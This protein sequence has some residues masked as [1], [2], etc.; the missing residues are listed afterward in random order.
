MGFDCTTVKMVNINC[1]QNDHIVLLDISKA[2]NATPA[3]CVAVRSQDLDWK[4][5]GVPT[6]T[7][8]TVHICT[9][10]SKIIVGERAIVFTIVKPPFPKHM[11]C[12]KNAH[13]CEE[14]NKK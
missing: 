7:T 5:A 14:K 8:T 4:V 3:I 1:C 13:S 6:Y 2:M 12:S 9:R 11:H 10:V